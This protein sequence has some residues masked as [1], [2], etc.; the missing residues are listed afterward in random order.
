MGEEIV[1]LLNLIELEAMGHQ[2]RVSTRPDTMAPMS[3]APAV[4]YRPMGHWA[5]TAT[6]S[7]MRM[8]PL[9]ALEKPV[10][11]M[12]DSE[13]YARASHAP[14]AHA[15]L[16]LDQ[17]VRHVSRKLKVP[18]NIT[19]VPLPAKAP[20]LNPVENIWQSMRDN[21]ISNQVFASYTDILDHCCR[22]VERQRQ[23]IPPSTTRRI[24]LPSRLRSPI[25]G[26]RS[27]AAGSCWSR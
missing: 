13:R 24:G 1:R 22:A 3:R 4:A 17:A 11:M 20:E 2:G 10:D 25:R 6:V 14:G 16:R 27:S 15:V 12:S 21:W 7:P 8:A 26:I 19:H 5:N 18:A 9:S 23:L